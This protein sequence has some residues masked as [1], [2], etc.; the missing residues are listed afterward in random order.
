MSIQHHPDPATLMSYAAGSLPEPLA[1]VVACHNA[2]CP[3]CR[4]D[5]AW[6]DE[7]GA[8][9]VD[10][11]PRIAVGTPAPTVPSTD[12]SAPRAATASS[13]P[14][15]G[16]DVPAPLVARVGTRLDAVAWKRLA[17]GIWH[18]PLP[19]SPG[20]S[21]D[22]RLI[23]VAPGLTMPEHGHGGQE[24]TLLLAGAYTDRVGRFARG[25]VSDL[26]ADTEH[27][28][29]A[30]ADAGCICLIASEKPARYKGW[31]ARLLQPLVGI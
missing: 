18:W 25:D 15:A 14:A 17:P 27:Q 1:A 4:A 23:K 3:V 21:G 26:D 19:L 30:D 2:L 12:A 6:L 31:I 9:L 5:M 24:M 16:G 29:V 8:A 7:A 11:L 28:P 20:V 13:S 22:L 10:A